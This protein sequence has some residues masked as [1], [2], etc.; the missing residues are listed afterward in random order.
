MILKY[1]KDL[2]KNSV[3]S[4]SENKSYLKSGLTI[5]STKDIV[6]WDDFELKSG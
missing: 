2:K 1:L 5:V 4:S 6:Y 3:T